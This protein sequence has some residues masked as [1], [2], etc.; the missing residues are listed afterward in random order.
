MVQSLPT[1]ALGECVLGLNVVASIPGFSHCSSP[2]FD[3]AL[4]KSSF[5]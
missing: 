1:A 4:Y 3:E 2:R 5:L